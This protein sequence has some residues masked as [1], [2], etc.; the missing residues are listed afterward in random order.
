MTTESTLDRF[1]EALNVPASSAEVAAETEVVTQMHGLLSPATGATVILKTIFGHKVAAAAAAMALGSTG[2]AAASGNVAFL[3]EE[4]VPA[5]T[6]VVAEVELES[7][8]QVAVQIEVVE[9]EQVE[10]EEDPAIIEDDEV[11][12]P[13]NEGEPYGDVV[14]DDAENH[15]HY[16]SGVAR[17]RSIESPRGQIISQAAQTD[18]GKS[19]DED[20]DVDEREELDETDELLD[21][22]DEED[23]SEDD[24]ENDD[25]DRR[26]RG[27]SN[28][29]G[30]KK[31]K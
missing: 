3:V 16:V 13:T 29:K 24:E 6:E 10:L 31:D 28:G 11:L 17:D 25:D 8:E 27:N 22:D 18:C 9:D 5:Q 30:P 14:C 23:E 12:P 19:D 15:G 2:V 4:E 21:D 26:G 1:A 20:D 7:T